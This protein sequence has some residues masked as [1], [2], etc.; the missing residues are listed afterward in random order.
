MKKDRAHSPTFSQDY[1]I[2]GHLESIDFVV[3]NNVGNGLFN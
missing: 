1:S 2:L 3:S